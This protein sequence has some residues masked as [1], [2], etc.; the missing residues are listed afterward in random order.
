MALTELWAS[1]EACRGVETAAT[2][3]SS[4]TDEQKTKDDD[5]TSNMSG[6]IEYYSM[7]PGWSETDGLTVALPAMTKRMGGNGGNLRDWDMAADTIVWLAVVRTDGDSDVVLHP[8]EF[9]LDREPVRKVTPLDFGV[10][11][12]SLK[13]VEVL[14]EKLE[15]MAG[16]SSAR[17]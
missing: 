7:H 14:E 11:K 3:T 17:A 6:R 16:L 9:Y 2:S 4:G 10:G 12:Y 13:Q 8:G 15:S 5:A 1:R